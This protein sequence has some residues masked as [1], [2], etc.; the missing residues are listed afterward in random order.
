MDPLNII[1]LLAVIPFYIELVILQ[2]YG[3]HAWTRVGVG[4]DPCHS[5]QN[6]SVDYAVFSLNLICSL[7]IVKKLEFYLQSVLLIGYGGG[8]ACLIKNT[9]RRL[10]IGCQEGGAMNFYRKF[11]IFQDHIYAHKNMRFDHFV[12]NFSFWKINRNQKFFLL[13][14]RFSLIFF[15]EFDYRSKKE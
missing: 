3:N 7:L 12:K 4:N 11:C 8:G 10:L 9:N 2:V 13:I 15:A 5:L 14:F 1:D 6:L